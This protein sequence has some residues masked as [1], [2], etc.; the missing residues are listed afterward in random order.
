MFLK[1]FKDRCIIQSVRAF[2]KKNQTQICLNTLFDQRRK[3]ENEWKKNKNEWND[4]D[5]E[6]RRVFHEEEMMRKKTEKHEKN[7]EPKCEITNK[8]KRTTDCSCKNM[9]I[10]RNSETHL[11]HY[12]EGGV[13]MIRKN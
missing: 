2:A 5:D 4:D 12:Y 3:I 7:E 1:L 13:G 11:I 8:K 10:V 9:C 6:Q